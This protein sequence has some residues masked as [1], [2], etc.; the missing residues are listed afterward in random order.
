MT[1]TSESQPN[2]PYQI[3]R[4]I[5]FFPRVVGLAV[6]GLLVA[7]GVSVGTAGTACACSCVGYT[8][9]EAASQADGVFVARVT[10]KVSAGSDDIYEFALL[11]IFKGDVGAITTV[12]TSSQGPSCGVS[13]DVGGEYF[14]FVSEGGGVGH[15]WESSLCHGPSTISRVDVRG[16]LERIYGPPHPPNSA[17]PVSEITWW[18]RATA[19]VPLP[20]MVLASV[21]LLGAIWW[22]VVIL[23]RRRTER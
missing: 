2:R 1:N 21:I 18:T 14:L 9:E 10:D 3:G 22:A 12:E 16:E 8:T 4:F 20:L 19:A 11:E 23:R 13:Y 5:R 15:A 17:A 7:T 6:C